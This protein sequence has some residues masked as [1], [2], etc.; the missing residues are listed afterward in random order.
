[1]F[2][3]FPLFTFHFSLVSLVVALTVLVAGCSMPVNPLTG[4]GS[5]RDLLH[6]ASGFVI[7]GT[8]QA[9]ATIELG[10]IG[11]EKAKSA[12]GDFQQRA[13][14]LQQGVQT[15]KKGMENV[16]EGKEL[17]EKAVAK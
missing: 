2:A 11:V 3:R 7:E 9:A 1:M 4:S 15:V 12:A 16:K 13:G 17:I 6:T 14:E 8:K 10:K 5:I